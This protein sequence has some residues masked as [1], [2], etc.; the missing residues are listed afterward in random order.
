MLTRTFSARGLETLSNEAIEPLSAAVPIPLVTKNVPFESKEPELKLFLSNNELTRLPG[1]IFNIEHLTVLSLRGNRLEE[2]P[3]SIGQL[4]NLHTLNIASN[5]LRYLPGSLLKLLHSRQMKD[6]IYHSNPF[7]C[8][9][10]DFEIPPL[11]KLIIPTW[12]VALP[13]A[14]Y[15]ART[16]VQYLNASGH[17]VTGE[18]LLLAEPYTPLLVCDV[19]EEDGMGQEG[20][21]D[22][23]DEGT[24]I[25]DNVDYAATPTSSSPRYPEGSFTGRVPCLVE[26]ALRSCYRSSQLL[27]ITRMLDKNQFGPLLTKLLRGMEIQKSEGGRVCCNCSH[28]FVMPMT[29]WVEFWDPAAIPTKCAEA[30]PFLKQGCSWS[31]LPSKQNVSQ[32][33]YRR[34]LS[35]IE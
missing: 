20:S 1:A 13:T 6:F 12:A 31:C 9:A 33:R 32:V 30:V 8:P 16:A 7:I 19:L 25:E 26:L 18:E 15:L 5:K 22:D 14:V 11:G 23:K 2:I 21:K 3:S 34:P 28:A 24:Q 17:S 10:K 27:E 29:Q 4:R 35:Q